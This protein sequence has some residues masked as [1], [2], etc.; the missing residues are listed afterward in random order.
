MLK[1]TTSSFLFTSVNDKTRSVKQVK[2]TE[3]SSCV[4]VRT[5]R[6]TILGCS[7]TVNLAMELRV[8][9]VVVL[10]EGRKLVCPIMKGFLV[11]NYD[12]VPTT[13]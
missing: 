12:L 8:N 1:I 3:K 6:I 11:L 5:H 10:H 9:S 13:V 7:Y 2:Y 4:D